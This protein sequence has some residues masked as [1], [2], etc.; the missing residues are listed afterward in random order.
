M[1][2]VIDHDAGA[3]AEWIAT[4]PGLDAP[5]RIAIY[6]NNILGN[7]RNAMA[8]VFRNTSNVLRNNSTIPQAT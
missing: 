4:A 6:R 1:R 3:V 2:A 8:N 7:Y 5:A